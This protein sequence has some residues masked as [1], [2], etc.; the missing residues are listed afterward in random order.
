MLRSAV[1]CHMFQQQRRV[2]S[3]R[4]L[5]I[6]HRARNPLSRHMTDIRGATGCYYCWLGEFDKCEQHCALVHARR[7]ADPVEA[8]ETAA[9]S[10]DPAQW[11]PFFT[12]APIL[13][14]T[15]KQLRSIYESVEPRQLR[16]QCSSSAPSHL[17][18][19]HEPI[20]F[21]PPYKH[22][23]EAT[24]ID[25]TPYTKLSVTPSANSYTHHH[26]QLVVNNDG[27][28]DGSL[29]KSGRVARKPQSRPAS[30]SM[31]TV[32]EDEQLG[33]ILSGRY[34]DAMAMPLPRIFAQI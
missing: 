30:R 9:K 11:N 6:A 27:V 23:R 21:F 13:S 29:V 18:S 3:D 15:A 12:A 2:E 10:V 24:L 25:V 17:R 33:S 19:L 14:H 5:Q 20:Q 34:S 8:A 4:G 31:P 26:G 7:I 28:W 22:P 32:R 1:G 16:R